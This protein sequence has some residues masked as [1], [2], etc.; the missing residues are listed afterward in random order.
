MK[1]HSAQKQIEKKGP[2]RILKYPAAVLLLVVLFAAQYLAS[3]CGTYVSGMFDYSFIDAD[4]LFAGVAVHHIVQMLCALAAILILRLIIKIKGFKLR[5]RVD[6]TGIKYTV[7]FCVL[8]ILYYLGVYIA[9]SYMNTINTY[10]YELNTINITGTLGFQ[11]LLSGPS[12]EILFRSLPVTVL[13]SVLDPENKFDQTL[14]VLG[15]AVLFGI[16]HIDL[17][18]FSIPWFQVGY[19]CLLGIAYGFAFVRSRSVIYPMIM[20]SMSNVISVGGCY[21]YMLFFMQKPV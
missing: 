15:A 3:R 21:L 17:V 7:V 9:G 13:L 8:L 5:P 20:H 14:A 18:T 19:A 10:D 16:A 11:L 1:K 2:M 12:E 6:S 4:G